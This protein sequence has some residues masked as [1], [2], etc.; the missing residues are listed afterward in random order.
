MRTTR[1][2][3]SKQRDTVNVTLLRAPWRYRLLEVEVKR[4]QILTK[5]INDRV[6]LSLSMHAAGVSFA[7]VI[8]SMLKI[9]ASS[10]EVVEI[11]GSA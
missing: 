4:F 7:C 5:F 8:C 9:V 6:R 1:S 2:R 3:F 11:D 10:G